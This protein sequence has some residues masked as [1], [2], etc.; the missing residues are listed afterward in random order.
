MIRAAWFIYLTLFRVDQ[1]YDVD[2][3]VPQIGKE[4]KTDAK[5]WS[6]KEFL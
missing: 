3:F 1:S 2:L 6:G 4:I 5:Y